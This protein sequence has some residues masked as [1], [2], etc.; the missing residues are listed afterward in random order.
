MIEEAKNDP[1]CGYIAVD[2]ESRFFRNKYETARVKGELLEYGVRTITSTRTADPR[3]VHGLWMETI[4]ETA[5]HA[6]SIMRGQYT[7]RGM[8][9]NIHK[10]DEKTG[11]A[12]KNGPA[13]YGWKAR[14]IHLGH[15]SRGRPINRTIWELDEPKAEVRRQILLWRKD[16]WSLEQCH[17]RSKIGSPAI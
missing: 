8:K 15:D 4:E 11:W 12:F 9:G 1:A 6:D 3:T 14:R 5:A 2:D 16:G 13:P 10:R 17:R 7:M